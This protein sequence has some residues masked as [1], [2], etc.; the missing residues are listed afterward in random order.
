MA[1]GETLVVLLVARFVS[2]IG[3]GMAFPAVRR[4]VINADPDNLGRNV[5]PQNTSTLITMMIRWRFIVAYL[6][7]GRYLRIVNILRDFHQA[8]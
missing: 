8:G 7:E 6:T 5:G 3:M 1:V 4:I 2:G